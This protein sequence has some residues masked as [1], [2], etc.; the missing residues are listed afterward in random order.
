SPSRSSPTATTKCSWIRP[1]SANSSKR[2]PKPP[3]RARQSPDESR[4]S[5]IG[6]V[7]GEPLQE[8]GK[9]PASHR[10][11]RYHP[12]RF[13]QSNRRHRSSHEARQ[14]EGSRGAACLP[15][16]LLPVSFVDPLNA[17]HVG[18]LV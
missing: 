11:C 1:P 4:L 12:P 10:D 7:P 16:P 6:V 15:R 8:P 5:V 2:C 13:A 14:P 9:Q 3:N 18:V 17:S